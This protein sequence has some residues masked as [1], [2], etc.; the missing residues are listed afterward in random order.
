M[1]QKKIQQP[2]PHLKNKF[3]LTNNINC[4]VKTCVIVVRIHL[5]GIDFNKKLKS[6]NEQ[7]PNERNRNA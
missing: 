3:L 2:T 7:N 1:N 4:C 5:K 6:V